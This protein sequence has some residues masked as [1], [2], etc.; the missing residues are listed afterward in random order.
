MPVVGFDML[1]TGLTGLA[2]VGP[3][4]AD[5]QKAGEELRDLI[6]S[7]FGIYQSA[8]GPYPAWAELADSTKASRVAAG[9]TENDPL[10][11]TGAMQDAVNVLE[12]TSS[13][14]DV[15]IAGGDPTRVAA[16]VMELGSVTRGIP[17]RAFLEPGIVR[18]E[19]TFIDRILA[20][21]RGKL[22]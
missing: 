21:I 2:S 12:V 22:P 13:Y 11:V 19:Q 1:F 5:L 4:H 7:E 8:V 6:K 15:G 17:Q 3:S 20:D 9:Y 14:V 18:Y 16:G 10:L